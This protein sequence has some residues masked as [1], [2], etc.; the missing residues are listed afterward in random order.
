[1]KE[2]ILQ[3]TIW[4]FSDMDIVYFCSYDW[5]GCLYKNLFLETQQENWKKIEN[6]KK[7]I[8][9]IT[10]QIIKTWKEF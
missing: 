4:L 9:Y 3:Q 2:G 10:N 8:I 6:T 1:M 5:Q 7:N